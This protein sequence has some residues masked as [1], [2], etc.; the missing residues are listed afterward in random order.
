MPGTL[1]KIPRT[2]GL[3]V[4]SGSL[5]GVVPGRRV[6]KWLEAN[7]IDGAG[8]EGL[9]PLE[10]FGDLERLE[11]ERLR[12][13]GLGVLGRLDRVDT[14]TLRNVGGVDFGTFAAPPRL[15]SLGLSDVDEDCAVPDRLTLPDDMEDISL[16]ERR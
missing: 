5:D 2:D 13:V 9:A 8:T 14:L 4:I 1:R 7:G 15:R 11:L 3:Y 16:V 12:N 6:V 10:A